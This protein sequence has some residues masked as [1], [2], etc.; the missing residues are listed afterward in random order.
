MNLSNF[1]NKLKISRNKNAKEKEIFTNIVSTLE[2]CWLR[3]NFIQTQLGVDFY[4]YEEHYFTII[5][6]LIYLKYGETAGS[7]VLW[8]VYDRYDK[9]GNL[10]TIEVT[11]NNKPKKEYKLKTPGDLWN[12]VEKIVKET[13]KL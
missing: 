8:Y 5:E 9:E 3:T 13:N 7:L 2:Q 6:D 1:G 4:N 10:Q 12:L 11:F